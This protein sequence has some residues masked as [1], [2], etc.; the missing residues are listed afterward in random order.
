[1][2]GSFVLSLLLVAGICLAL[3]TDV[4]E[5]QVIAYGTYPYYGYPYSYG[6]YGYYGP[7]G[8]PYASY[9]LLKK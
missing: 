9:A 4:S 8:Y 7:Y 6:Y 3:M 5:A 1:M 2:K